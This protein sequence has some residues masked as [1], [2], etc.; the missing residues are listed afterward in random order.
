MGAHQWQIL[1]GINFE[2]AVAVLGALLTPT[3]AVITAYVAYQQWRTN[4]TRLDLDL[5]DRRLAIYKALEE[6]YVGINIP[7][8]IRYPML[9]KLRFSTAEARFL[10]PKEIENHLD[11]LHMK[12]FRAAQLREQLY[13]ISK[14]PGLPKGEARSKAVDEESKLLQEIQGPL[15]N[16][17][18]KLFRKYL[19]LA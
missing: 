11:A 7:G 18:K 2:T 4:K 19:T 13:P 15:W 10:F 1:W 16:E 6:F 3:I 8:D 9:S 5:Y 12:G 14:E 17:S